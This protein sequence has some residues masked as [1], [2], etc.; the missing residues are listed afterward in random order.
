VPGRTLVGLDLR[1]LDRYRAEAEHVVSISSRLP[2]DRHL[3]LMDVRLEEFVPRERLEAEIRKLCGGRD[4]W[5]LR[6]DRHFH[7]Y[8]DLLLEGRDW[9]RWNLGFQQWL[10]LTDPRYV[11][12]S[13][14]EGCN[15]LRLNAGGQ[16]HSR[17]PTTVGEPRPTPG[18]IATSALQLAQ[19][20]HSWQLRRS[21]AHAV[22]HVRD[23]AE[24]AADIGAECLARGISLDGVSLEELFAC[25]CLHDCLED[26]NTDYEDVERVAGDR[27]AELV[28]RLSM[29]KRL[30]EARRRAEYAQQLRS[31][32]LP[33]RIVKLADLLSNLIG[34]TNQEDSHWIGRYLG[35][36]EAHLDLI[37]DQL[38]ETTAFLEAQDLIRRWHRRLSRSP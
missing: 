36:V 22:D 28:A 15:L 31:A 21:G 9:M 35:Q 34:L 16:F 14:L 7:V 13:L 19:R 27:V 17:V 4:M 37:R 8:G 1:D 18:P 3:A 25:G 10:T 20:R 12:R 32:G 11:A 24:L 5:L 26:T 23:V 29:D 38:D 30:P 2:G 6:T 33:A